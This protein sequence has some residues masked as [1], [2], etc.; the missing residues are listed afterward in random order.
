M[1]QVWRGYPDTHLLLAGARTPYSEQIT[2]IIRRLPQAQQEKITVVDD[3]DEDEKADLLSACD[4]FVLPSGQESFGIAFLEAWA[5]AKPVIGV[6]A[7]AVPSVIDEGQDGLLVRD[8]DTEALAG[9]ITEM[10]ENPE[11]RTRMGR[12]GQQKVLS[13]YTWKTV[14]QRVR[15]VYQEVLSQQS[16]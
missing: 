8:Q 13:R 2:S 14:T 6:R 11:R 12:A 9:A 3:F 1:S 15:E 10:L 7:G 16:G 4:I 5:C